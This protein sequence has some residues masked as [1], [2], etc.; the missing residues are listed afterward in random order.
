MII[1]RS[2][3]F[4]IVPAETPFNSGHVVLKS[5][6]PLAHLADNE[7]AELAASLKRIVAKIESVYRP[8]GYNVLLFDDRIEIVPRWCGDISF[9]A[10]LGLKT[11]PQTPQMIYE[12]LK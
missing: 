1:E 11:T 12:S 8:E 7:V 9:V 4:E 3:F 5:S 2:A 10:L 6:K